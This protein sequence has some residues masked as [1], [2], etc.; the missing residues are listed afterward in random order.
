MCLKFGHWGMRFYML[1]I[2][3]ICLF[4][5]TEPFQVYSKIDIICEMV[6]LAFASCAKMII[7]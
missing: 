3:C 4:V 6:L 2:C 7:E 5:P 1:V